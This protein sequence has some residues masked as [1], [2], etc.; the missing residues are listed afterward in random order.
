MGRHGLEC[1][2]TKTWK[3]EYFCFPVKLNTQVFNFAPKLYH[4]FGARVNR[5]KHLCCILAQMV[6]W[7]FLPY[8]LPM[9]TIYTLE[10][11]KEFLAFV[12]KHNLTFNNQIEVESAIA[13]YFLKD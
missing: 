8:N 6:F 3:N 1:W 10:Q 11:I 7:R 5:G 2:F 12:A 4:N 9:K 13:Q